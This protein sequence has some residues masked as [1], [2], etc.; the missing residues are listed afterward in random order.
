MNVV[1]RA[2]GK[3]GSR[4]TGPAEPMLCAMG[5]RGHDHDF[6]ARLSAL[7]RRVGP[8]ESPGGASAPILDRGAW[9]KSSRRA[10]LPTW[11][12]PAG[13]DQ[14]TNVPRL[15]HGQ[16]RTPWR[17]GEAKTTGFVSENS[18]GAHVYR[19]QGLAL[20]PHGVHHRF[21]G[22][23][24][25]TGVVGALRERWGRERFSRILCRLARARA[26]ARRLP[27]APAPRVAAARPRRRA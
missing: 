13:I 20:G 7:L 17:A 14:V 3:I 16:G 10:A 27:T 12:T 2:G 4:T 23:W 11:C 9:C 1:G 15:R 26:R 8:H 6:G 24:G 18:G 5:K 19:V 21:A 25:A 22:A